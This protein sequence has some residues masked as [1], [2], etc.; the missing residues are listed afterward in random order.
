[1]EGGGIYYRY[2]T[3]LLLIN[4]RLVQFRHD[5]QILLSKVRNVGLTY[6]E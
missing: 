3:K 1:M 6:K 5:Y 4:N 2:A